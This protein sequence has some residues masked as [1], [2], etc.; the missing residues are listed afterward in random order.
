LCW[1]IRPTEHDEEADA[2]MIDTALATPPLQPLKD[3]WTKIIR[4][5][6]GWFDIHLA[7]LW[8]YRDLILL[9][10]WRDFVKVYKQTILGPL[11]Y[12]IQ[13]ILTTVV[14]IVYPL[15]VVP[16]RFAMHF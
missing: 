14:F 1:L 2:A 13:P 15:S 3:Q 6:S 5:R 7:E 9:F 16:E 12:V 4:P 10:V 8:R 11:W